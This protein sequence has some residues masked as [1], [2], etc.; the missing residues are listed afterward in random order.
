MNA[1]LQQIDHWLFTHWPRWTLRYWSEPHRPE[2][3]I[4]LEHRPTRQKFSFVVD[5]NYQRVDSKSG[6]DFVLRNIEIILREHATF[7]E[8]LFATDKAKF[9]EAK[10]NDH[11]DREIER[12]MFELPQPV[13]VPSDIVPEWLAKPTPEKLGRVP[14]PKPAPKPKPDRGSRKIILEDE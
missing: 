5:E 9:N 14:E 1:A 8:Y 2:T 6:H 3:T 13:L 11:M 7:E 10:F 4:Q 12:K